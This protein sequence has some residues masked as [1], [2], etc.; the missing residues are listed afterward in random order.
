MIGRGS[1][2]N[3]NASASS[4]SEAV[5]EVNGT[6]APDSSTRCGRHQREVRSPPHLAARQV[7][8]AVPAKLLPQCQCRRLLQR[9]PLLPLLTTR[10][11]ACRE[12]SLQCKQSCKLLAL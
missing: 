8:P 12:N 9:L 6:A 1:S 3:N 2:I 7:V 11:H 5:G 4:P 10:W